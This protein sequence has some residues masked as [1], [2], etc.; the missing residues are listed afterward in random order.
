[1]KTFDFQQFVQDYQQSYTVVIDRMGGQVTVRRSNMQEIDSRGI[2][3][4]WTKV[5]PIH[6]KFLHIRRVKMLM[7]DCTVIAVWERGN[8]GLV[9][10]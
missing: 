9:R 5:G 4:V 3:A 6:I 8:D 2:V 1:M 7:S 10:V